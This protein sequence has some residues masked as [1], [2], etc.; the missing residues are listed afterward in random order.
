M[1]DDAWPGIFPP[2]FDLPP[3]HRHVWGNS[4]MNLLKPL[5]ISALALVAASSSAGAATFTVDVSG[6]CTVNCAA[7]GLA[8]NEAFAGVVGVDNATFEAGQY[9]T[10]AVA[11][12]SF[13]FGTFAFSEA[14]V[15]IANNLVQWGSTPDAVSE[16][17]IFA[18]GSENPA[19]PGPY[20]SLSATAASLGTGYAALDAFYAVGDDGQWAGSEG[21]GAYFNLDV[22]SSGPRPPT[23]VPLPAAGWLL[24]GA[25]LGFAGLRRAGRAT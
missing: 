2:G 20:L 12:F 21:H 6:W 1:I 19:A 16:I 8:D 7:V 4:Q 17:Y 24:A 10:S 18:F 23:P 15:A 25:L 9:D 11:S 14:D 22:L 3:Q 5:G 13:S